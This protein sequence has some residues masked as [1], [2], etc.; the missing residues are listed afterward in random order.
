[1]PTAAF[2]GLPHSESE[3]YF[4]KSSARGLTTSATASGLNS[5]RRPYK[6]TPFN[7]NSLK[8]VLVVMFF[9]TQNCGRIPPSRPLL[10]SLIPVAGPQT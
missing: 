8:G 9:T 3:V 7:K 1:M 2:W 10:A 4:V 5:G 6:K